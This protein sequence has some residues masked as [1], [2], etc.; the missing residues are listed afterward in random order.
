MEREPIRAEARRERR[1]GMIREYTM[2]TAVKCAD[3]MMRL[4]RR[5]DDDRTMTGRD[6]ANDDDDER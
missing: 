5:A 4:Q 3:L 6:D 2:M 1:R